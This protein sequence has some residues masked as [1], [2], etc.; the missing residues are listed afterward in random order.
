[1]LQVQRCRIDGEAVA[2]G[3]ID[4]DGE[5]AAPG[6]IRRTSRTPCRGYRLTTSTTARP[7]PVPR[8]SPLPLPRR[9]SRTPCRGCRPC[10][11]DG[12][13]VARLHPA[14]QSH[15]VPRR[16][17]LPLPL[18][19]GARGGCNFD[20]GE[21]VALVASGEP[22]ARRRSRCP[23]FRS[24]EQARRLASPQPSFF[25][26][27]SNSNALKRTCAAHKRGLTNREKGREDFYSR[28]MTY[29]A[30]IRARAICFVYCLFNH[31]Q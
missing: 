30:Q 21:A 3:T 5:A 6:C 8:S 2:P 1:M 27:R 9:T 7:L 26:F 12:E 16:L 13:A 11:F 4:G 28:Y 15:T 19:H 31:S 25:C 29:C 17:P 22:V 10:H 20:D 18:V 14:N 24:G 23:L